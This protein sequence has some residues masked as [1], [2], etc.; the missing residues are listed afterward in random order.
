MSVKEQLGLEDPDRGLLRQARARWVEWAAA[1][2]ALS[3]ARD[4]VEVPDWARGVDAA[5]EDE[6]LQV[7][8]RLASPRGG[9]DVEAAGALAW[10]LLPGACTLAYR[11]RTLSP[12]IDEVV[13]AQLWLE[14]R[15][16]SWEQLRKVA[17]N[18]LLNTRRGVLRELE[19]GDH[20][21][22][23]DPTWSLSEPVEPDARLWTLRDANAPTPVLEPKREL[24]AVLNHAIRSGAIAPWERDL[25]LTLAAEA[26]AAGV[27]R[28]GCGR[29]GL[30]SGVVSRTVARSLG[31]SEATVRRRAMAALDAVTA[32]ATRMP[33]AS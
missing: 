22:E 9:D 33:A 20:A 29:A 8:A 26:D 23:A 18:V 3:V 30:C 28:S 11:L 7:L 4:L 13:A 31:T 2:P 32:T 5:A 10:L 6:V 25:L 19:V 14:V 21:R 27:A 15:S 17:A 24:D 12:R 1:E 16:F